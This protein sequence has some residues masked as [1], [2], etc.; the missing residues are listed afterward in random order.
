MRTHLYMTF[1][2][3]L[4]AID[5]LNH[6]RL[7][8][9]MQEFGCPEEFTH[10]VRRLHDGILA[11]VTEIRTV[12]EA[13]AVLNG[14]KQG[15]V[16][17]PTLFRL[18]YPVML[19]KAYRDEYPVIRSSY[20]T[21]GHLLNIWRVQAPPCVSTTSLHDLLVVDECNLNFL[22]EKYLRRSMDLFIIVCVTFRLTV[23]KD[24]TKVLHKPPPSAEYNAHR[25][26]VIV[27][28]IKPVDNWEVCCP[29][30]S[31]T[32]AFIWNGQRPQ[33]NTKLKMY[34]AVFTTLLYEAE[35]WTVYCKQAKK[36]NHFHL[37]GLHRILKLR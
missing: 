22:M 12:S 3:L 33:M 1:M 34:K 23:N 6:N 27:T 18:L 26:Y 32:Q 30:T 14:V 37:S 7:W 25:I 4:T 5:T 24:Q 17:A 13:F 15:C 10:M 20:R 11:H 2:D 8:K 9:T 35:S 16:L 28:E 29:S 31:N 19:M 21:V 36:L